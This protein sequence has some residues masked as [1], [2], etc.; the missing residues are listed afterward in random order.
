[1]TIDPA[2]LYGRG[3]AFPL[4]V[5]A[6]GRVRWSEGAYDVR[7]SIRLILE[8]AP[9]ERVGCPEFGAGLRQLLHLPNTVTTRARVQERIQ[10]A[11]TRWEPRVHVQSVTVEEDPADP[12]SAIATLH[13]Q[14]V[15]T[16]TPESL[17]VVVALQG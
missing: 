12:S 11:L 16:R 6:D 7:Q 5:G 9:G 13:Y 8:T 10:A 4:D 1:M 15:A 17:S 3:L 14:L 2:L